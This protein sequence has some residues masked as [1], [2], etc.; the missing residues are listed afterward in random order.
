[1]EIMGAEPTVNSN[2]VFHF[3]LAPIGFS[4]DAGDA[5]NMVRLQFIN[6]NQDAPGGQSINVPVPTNGPNA[7]L[8]NHWYHV[9][10]AYNGGFNSSSNLALYWTALDS[11]ATNITLLAS[12]AVSNPIPATA[13]ST[14]I[15]GNIGRTRFGN[16]NRPVANNFVGLIDEVRMSSVARSP[17]E[18]Q[19][20]PD[21]P[22]IVAQPVGGTYLVGNSITL[23]ARAAGQPMLNY[24]WRLNGINI[25]GATNKTYLVANSQVAN[26]GNYDVI[27]VN[28]FGSVT[29]L[30]ATLTIMPLPNTS[31]AT[32]ILL[33]NG[34]SQVVS[35]FFFATEPGSTNNTACGSVYRGVWYMVTP[36]IN[37]RVIISTAGSSFPT[38]LAI[39][40]NTCGSLSN[41][42]CSI[43]FT[44]TPGV[45]AVDFSSVSNVT[46]HILAGGY[47]P[48]PSGN[49]VISATL[50]NPP[51]NDICAGAIDLTVVKTN[52]QS[53][54]YATELGDA[55]EGCGGSVSH[56]V[57]Y[58]VTPGINQRVI[59]STAGSSFPTALSVYTNTCGSLSNILCSVPFT[60]TPGVA[61]V[62]FSSVSNVTYHILAGGYNGNSGNLVMSVT[63]T[64]PPANDICAG[65]ID[66]TVVKTNTQ[67]TTYATELGDATD[68]CG[69]S[70]SH[71]VWYTVTPGINQ[72]VI[73]STAGSSFPTA[74]SVYTNTCG[75]LSNILCSVP[76]TGTPGVASVD[77]SSV[78][79][80]TYHILAGGYNGN[81]GNLAISVTLTNPPANDICA[82]AIDLTVVRTNTQSTTY[83]TE[84]GDATDGC[85]TS[86][87]H[88]VWYTVTP[89][90][91]QRVIINT[92]GSSFPTALSVYTN[93]CGSLS[94]ILCSVPFTG[95]PGVASVDFSSVSNVTYHILAGGYNGNSGN[96]A[97]SV[98]L[99]NPP[100]N[101]IC[102]GAIDLTVVRTNTQSTTYATEL[103]DAA[104]GC[105][106]SV[107]HGVWYTVTP[108]INQRVIISTAGSSFPT[109]L[110]VY[111]NTCGSLSNILCSVPFTGTP[112]VASVDFSGVSNVSYHVLAG[113]YNG[114]SGTLMVTV[115]LLEPPSILTQPLSQLVPLGSNVNFSVVSTGTPSL[116]YRWRFNGTNL[117]DSAHIVGSQTTNLSVLNV[118][119][120]DIGSYQVVITNAIGSVT[121]AIASLT[122]VKATPAVT[123]SNP[124]A[125]TY[126]TA[127]LPPLVSDSRALHA[128]RAAAHAP[129]ALVPVA[130]ANHFS[131]M[132]ELSRADSE[133]TRQVL[134]LA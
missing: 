66:L 79:N 103:G 21:A 131:I 99:T 36:G 105:G 83:A 50:T 4:A 44:G 53:T 8:S 116:F 2:R 81:S 111:T 20:T 38:A 130:G 92:A 27:A 25:S 11:G 94:N 18:M 64:N 118:Q 102:A 125:I 3:R 69:T 100:A 35:N 1:M 24:Q 56:G 107:S 84:L 128:K 26:S 6:V 114:N 133:L 132:Q 45:A 9:A 10:A 113:G 14:F 89:G 88:G 46:Y 7:I 55:T 115:S 12:S 48:A 47:G 124:V 93:T 60:G 52:T 16:T 119:S 122:L 34:A 29:S 85:G 96:L 101:D 19:L 32:A 39:Y 121:S 33:T 108:G 67:S 15:V 70:V 59:I 110:S 82:G 86:V 61:S 80:V 109:A 126:G 5:T 117:S 95:T 76:F 13:A 74:L 22:V 31:C 63:L 58:T 54:T 106:G 134:L 49:L 30:V 127:E 68:G 17:L 62:D 72:R 91:N 40:T 120:S 57:W 71:G 90:I 75:S 65:A 123:W 43:P 23:A 51:A 87:S 104:E 77:F 129:G 28:G 97:I 41:V 78:S 37:Q 112:G 98:T 42:L 73:I